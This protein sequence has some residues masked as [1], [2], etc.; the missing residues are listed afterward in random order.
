MSQR[1]SISGK[2]RNN[3]INLRPKEHACLKIRDEASVA[4]VQWSSEKAVLEEV[5]EPGRGAKT[6]VAII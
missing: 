4:G 5:G 3:F 1:K 2:R 6:L